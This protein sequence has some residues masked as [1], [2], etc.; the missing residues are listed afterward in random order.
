VLSTVPCLASPEITGREALTGA[1]PVVVVPMSSASAEVCFGLTLAA[2]ANSPPA[3]A[4]GMAA[5]GATSETGSRIFL[6]TNSAF[7]N[8]SYFPQGIVPSSV[9]AILPPEA[10]LPSLSVTVRAGPF[11]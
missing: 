8:V 10:P 5:T 11:L 1:L 3:L 6:N 4:T 2:C 9:M 7:P